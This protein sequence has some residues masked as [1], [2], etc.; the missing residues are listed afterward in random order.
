MGKHTAGTRRESH[1]SW[2]RLLAAALALVVAAAAL[3]YWAVSSRLLGRAAA[4]ASP[5]A[6]VVLPTPPPPVPPHHKVHFPT[7]A[8]GAEGPAVL[9][10]QQLLAMT[11]YLPL[12]FNASSF[13]RHTI[14]PA[15]YTPVDPRVGTWS[16]TYWKTPARLRTLWTPGVDTVMVKGAVMTFEYVHGMPTDGIA[17]PAVWKALI[18]AAKRGKTDPYVYSWVLVSQ[19]LPQ[20]L[21]LWQGGKVVLVTPVNTGIPQ[22]PTQN[23]TWPVYARFLTTTM[24]GTDPSGHH[25]SDPGVPWVS[26]FNGGDAVHGFL[27]ASYGFPQSLGCVELPYANAKVA[28]GHM[29]YGTLVT[30]I[31]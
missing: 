4:R 15:W 14:A 17:G 8:L 18:A 24:S 12:T 27:R 1:R 26:Y 3:G 2:P 28:F 23:G 6:T 11:G 5:V 10:L 7:L 21:T 25:Y 9:R 31:P 16:W 30:V 29:T 20:K 19:T 22:A 13:R